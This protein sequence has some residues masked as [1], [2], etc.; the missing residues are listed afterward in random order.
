ME[1]PSIR[2]MSALLVYSQGRIVSLQLVLLH[3]YIH[4]D[5]DCFYLRLRYHIIHALLPSATAALLRIVHI[6]AA[7]RSLMTA[8]M[9]WLVYFMRAWGFPYSLWP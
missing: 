4:K 8:V 7:A 3:T 5:A 9:A 1:S 2:C 6:I